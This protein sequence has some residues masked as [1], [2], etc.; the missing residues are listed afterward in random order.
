MIE[1]RHTARRRVY[2]GGRVR[3]VAFLLEIEC[4]VRDVSLEGAR[5]C[6]SADTVL[7]DCFDLFIPCRDEMRRVF[8][9]WRRETAIGL[10]FAV[11][12]A[13]SAPEAVARRLAASEA[14]V[15]RLRAALL[16]G[17]GPEPG[18]VH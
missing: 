17:N 3:H 9:A 13:A 18:R 6:V 15:A 14:E 7:P 4:I 12:E 16:G 2:L 5:I 8:I 11:T 10:G 1:R